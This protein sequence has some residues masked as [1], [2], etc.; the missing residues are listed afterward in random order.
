MGLPRPSEL[1][2]GTAGHVDHGKTTIIEKLTGVWTSRHSEELMRGITI[3]IGYADMP[4][5]RLRNKRG[6][7]IYWSYPSYGDY[8]EPE[9]L[10]VVSFVDCPGHESL[11]AT[12]LAGATV[13]DGAML[14]IASNEPIP[15]PQTKEHVMAL[16]IMG[17]K[18]VVVVQNKIDLVS[19]EEAKESY[20]KI[21]EFLASTEYA[22]API[23]P[24]SAIHRINLHRLVE[25]LYKFIPPPKRDLTKPLR[26]YIIRSFDINKPGTPIDK[27]QGG[28]IG[29]SI[30]QGKVRVGDEI[31]IL[32][33][34]L[35]SEGGKIKNT[36][37]ITKVTSI[38]AGGLELKEAY[39]GGL[40]GIQTD[41]DPYLTKSD[42]LVGNIAGEPGTLP[43][44]TTMLSLE[45]ELFK[46][47]V[48]A[49]ETIQ[50]KPFEV[51]E[52]IRINIGPATS[53]GTIKS[54]TKEYVN[55]QLYRPV[56]AEIGWRAALAAR[57]GDSWRLVGVGRV[58]GVH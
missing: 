23:I 44:V 43:P 32:P 45:Y 1:N 57:V 12:M 55:V 4:I 47:V 19:K 34:Y 29:G 41:L 2:I 10:R 20:L 9:L 16:Q 17:V 35:Y 7:E 53:L 46:Y 27:L 15:R 40:V 52:K 42:S 3:K 37:L 6:E 36:P 21:K 39:G 33:G 30:F 31:E 25:A 56:V 48:G 49:D 58:I 54:V 28:V 18:N 11:M 24:V 13:M 26:F 14:V 5:Y 22:D 38:R 50:V 8:G 51:N